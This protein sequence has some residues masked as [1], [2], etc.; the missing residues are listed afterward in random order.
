MISFGLG[1][2]AALLCVAAYVLREDL[3]DL[4]RAW[5]VEPDRNMR[6]WFVFA[7]RVV[8]GFSILE[9]SWKIEGPNRV[10]ISRARAVLCRSGRHEA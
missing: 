6:G 7:R 9:P 10:R 1:F 4:P 5:R 3:A 2:L 8:T